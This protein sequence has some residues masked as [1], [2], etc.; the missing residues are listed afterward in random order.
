[1]GS[2]ADLR[3][4]LNMCHS[5]FTP[6]SY[7]QLL[8]FPAPHRITTKLSWITSLSGWEGLAFFI[9]WLTQPF[10]HYSLNPALHLTALHRPGLLLSHCTWA[11]MRKWL[12]PLWIQPPF[13][14]EVLHW[15]F[16]Y[17]CRGFDIGFY[18]QIGLPFQL[19]NGL[20]LWLTLGWNGFLLIFLTHGELL[21]F[22]VT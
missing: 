10:F 13:P 21:L 14:V 17:N 19:I 20:S 22:T 1:M 11:L 7:S 4:T 16:F 8:H 5:F 12:P 18:R 2:N 3:Q 6:N 9:K 15:I